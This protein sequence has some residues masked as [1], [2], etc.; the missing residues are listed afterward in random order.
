MTSLEDQ[1]RELNQK[2]ELKSN[3]IELQSK[4]IKYKDE[5]LLEAIQTIKELKEKK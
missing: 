5:S 2:I 1:I 4:I 3:I